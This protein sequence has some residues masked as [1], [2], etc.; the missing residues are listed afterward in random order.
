MI[1]FVFGVFLTGASAQTA[2]RDTIVNVFFAN[3]RYGLGKESLKMD[4]VARLLMGDAS[5]S[6]VTLYGYASN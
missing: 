2:A 5:D 6:K 3:D 1:A 4:S